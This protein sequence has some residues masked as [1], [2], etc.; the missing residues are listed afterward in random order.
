MFEIEIPLKH[1]ATL[2]LHILGDNAEDI[3]ETLLNG[4]WLGRRHNSGACPI[5]VFLTAIPAR[6][7]RRGRR[8]QSAHHPPGRRRGAGHR[9]R[10]PAGRRRVR[11]RLRHRGVSGTHRAQRRRGA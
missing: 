11:P 9:R 8:Q 5:A 4:N 2:A 10:P 3:A 1:H 6:C 7:A